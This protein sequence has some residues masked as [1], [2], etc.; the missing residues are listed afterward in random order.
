MDTRERSDKAEAAVRA[1]DQRAREGADEK[2]K[3]LLAEMENLCQVRGGGAGWCLVWAMYHIWMLF[4]LR[5]PLLVP[6]C[7]VS[8]AMKVL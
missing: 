3:G 1:A 6:R 8:W 5:R 7:W 4:F 2:T